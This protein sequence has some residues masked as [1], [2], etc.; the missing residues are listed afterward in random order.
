MPNWRVDPLR[1]CWA[2][3]SHIA[4]T[5]GPMNQETILF[6]PGFGTRFSVTVDT[7]EEFDWSADLNRNS[8]GTAATRALAE[9]QAWFMQAGVKPLYYVDQPVVDDDAAAA[10]LAMLVADGSADVG[11]HLHPWVTPPHIEDVSRRNSYVGNL[12]RELEQTKLRHVRDAI[13]ARIGVRPVAYR[14]GRYGIGP[15]TLDILAEEGF[16]LDSSVRSLFDYRDDGGPDFRREQLA[17]WRCGPHGAIVEIPLT[18]VF[19]GR[20]RRFGPAAYLG[21][22]QFP[23][24]KSFLARAGWMERVPLTPEGIPA[25]KA[26]QGI[27]VAV[28]TGLPLLTM[29]FHSPS[30]AIG[31]TPYV[32]SKAD[33]AAFYR[34]FDI[35]L[36]HCA[37][38]GVLPVDLDGILAATGQGGRTTA[39]C[40]S[41]APSARAAA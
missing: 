39:A 41:A 35:V 19:T 4:V 18:T 3:S 26:C 9:G 16:L 29:S 21:M 32:R 7:E 31:H 15:N 12:P 23:T 6:P 38:R 30:L 14:A 25:D 20:L 40:Q 10:L 2:A 11:V 37:R 34:W 24:V 8:T 36:G 28:D 17:P 5:D 27:D 33:L 13:A 1:A 22:D